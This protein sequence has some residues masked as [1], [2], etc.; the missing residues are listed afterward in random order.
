[1]DSQGVNINAKV[2]AKQCGAKSLKYGWQWEGKNF[3]GNGWSCNATCDD[4]KLG[5]E[6]QVRFIPTNPKKVHCVPDDISRKTG[7]PKYID[8]IIFVLILLVPLWIPIIRYGRS[9]SRG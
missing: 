5:D 1:M 8:S 6:V 7:P 3:V 4:A 9:E 2:V